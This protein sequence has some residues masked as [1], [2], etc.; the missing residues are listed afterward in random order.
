MSEIDID[1]VIPWVDG[2]DSKWEGEKNKYL[3]IDKIEPREA[4]ND[5]SKASI[6]DSDDNRFRDWDILK[7]WFRS[8]E[9]NAPWVRKI[10]FITYG[11]LPDFLNVNNPKLNIVKHTD[12]IP[13][14]YLPTFSSHTIE[15]NMHRIN[16]LA[17]HFVYFNDDFFIN[18]KIDKNTFFLNGKP[19]YEALEGIVSSS[20]INEI[21]WHIIMNNMSIINSKFNKRAVYKNH[22]WKWINL[23]YGRETLRN[24]CLLPWP[25]FGSIVN[26]HVAVPFLKSTIEDVWNNEY[27]ELNKTSMNKFRSITDVNQYLFRYWDIVRGNFIPT[28]NK[29]MAYHMS[30]CDIQQVLTD[31]TDE[32]HDVICINDGPELEDFENKKK[33][34]CETFEKRYPKKSSF[35]I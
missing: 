4:I 2:R 23:K 20:D 30:S 29:G 24:L 22:F 14:E 16:G 1:F 11:H 35:E 15:L 26:R 19:R 6:I 18:T 7:Y 33:I 12:Y 5:E 9:V 31:I 13:D 32:I 3:E 10:H 34:I 28:K 17:E 21:Y 25:N 27:Q 8:V